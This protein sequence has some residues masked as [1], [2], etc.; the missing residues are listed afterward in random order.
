VKPLSISVVTLAALL[1]S[2][3]AMADN[4]QCGQG[5][6]PPCAGAQGPPGPAG[7][8]GPKGDPGEPGAPG[9]PGESIVGPAGKDGI[10]GKDG[11][12]GVDG[13]DGAAGVAG[14]DGTNFNA[15]EALAL[16]AALSMPAWLETHEN[17]RVS[18]GLGFSE[19]GETAVGATG[20][21]R[22]DKNLAGFGGAAVNTNGGNWA[23]KAGLSVGW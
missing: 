21:V 17:F 14:K 2:G 18:G 16:S 20:V 13:K 23:G 8:A 15:S 6:Q 12:D 10:D 9:A 5:N 22:L 3:A 19:G 7:P 1:A 11:R 4:P